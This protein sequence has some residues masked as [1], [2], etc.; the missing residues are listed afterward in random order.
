[1]VKKKIIAIVQTRLNSIRF[2]GKALKK[3]NGTTTIELLYRRLKKSKQIDDIVIATSKNR[4]NS[5]LINFLL[6]SF[7][8]FL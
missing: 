1:M 2:P 4:K 6:V 3:I 7:N 8:F 5:K